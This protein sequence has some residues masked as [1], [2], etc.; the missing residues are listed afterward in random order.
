MKV[1]ILGG[2][3]I[4]GNELITRAEEL[5]LEFSAPTSSDLDIRSLERVEKFV[6]EYSPE[7]IINA[8]AWTDVDAAEEHF[9]EACQI[10]E[11]G[12]TNI[13]KAGNKVGAKIIHV[14][15]DYVFNGES[16]TPYSETDTT[17]PVNKYGESKLRGERVLG[18][19]VDPVSYIV[20]TSWLYGPWGKNF[21]KIIA[22]K[23]LT[24]QNCSVVGDQFGSPT[25]A[26][27]LARGL[28]SITSK[29]PEPGVF[30]FSN[31]DDC[32][33]LDFAR[34]IF[35]CLGRDPKDVLEISS[36]ELVRKA[37]RPKY[38]L[39]NKEKWVSVGLGDI[40]NWRDSLG[41][42]IAEI[43]KRVRWEQ[44]I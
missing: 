11:A 14:S 1:L 43:E 35:Q 44:K 2:T 36:L 12:I 29:N 25:N 4:L 20:R 31:K 22:G 27:D 40:P 15:T 21:V 18:S 42:A 7:F 37:A 3:G 19:S 33:W 23:A 13:A 24:G 6:T 9:D 39:L 16:R 8:A 5:G 34:E 41:S 32:S 17:S 26:A 28:F 30:H 38:S 10:N